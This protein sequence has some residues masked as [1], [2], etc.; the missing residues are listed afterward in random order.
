MEKLV[1]I[2][3]VT[4]LIDLLGDVIDGFRSRA[5]RATQIHLSKFSWRDT[6]FVRDRLAKLSHRVIRLGGQFARPPL[7]PVTRTNP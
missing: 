1:E 3:E 4:R 6:R 2:D 7:R 5:R